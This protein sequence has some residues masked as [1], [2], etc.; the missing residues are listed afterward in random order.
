MIYKCLQEPRG[1]QISNLGDKVQLSIDPLF[2]AESVNSRDHLQCEWW[3]K[4]K[5]VNPND[6]NFEDRNTDTLKIK[7]FEKKYEGVYTCVVSAKSNPA[8]SV[9]AEVKLDL[10]LEGTWF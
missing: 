1:L 8:V 10:N 2:V 4:R 3:F 6:P 5:R 7:C 9:S